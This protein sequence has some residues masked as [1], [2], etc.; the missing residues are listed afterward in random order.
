MKVGTAGRGQAEFDGVPGERHVLPRLLA[1]GDDFKRGTTEI[2]EFGKQRAQLQAVET[3][4]PGM[5][6]DGN[7][8][9]TVNPR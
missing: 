9:A 1:A 6:N 7:P 4:A 5:R 2:A 3:I 8:A